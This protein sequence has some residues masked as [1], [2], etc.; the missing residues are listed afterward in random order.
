[1]DVS[2]QLQQI[3]VFFTDDGFIA[4]L[5][6]MPHPSVAVVKGHGITGHE[7]PGVIQTRCRK[8]AYKY[9]VP[10]FRRTPE[11]IAGD[12]NPKTSLLILI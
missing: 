5:K 8:V 11:S 3:G 2:D 6:Q 1:M 7:P 9:K 4:I 10:S 12:I